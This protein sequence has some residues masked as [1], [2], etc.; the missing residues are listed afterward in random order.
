LTS[1]P[2]PEHD[3]GWTLG[4]LLPTIARAMPT[5][6]TSPGQG[7][8]RP[9]LTRATPELIRAT[10]QILLGVIPL[11]STVLFLGLLVGEHN[12]AVDFRGWYWP[13]GHRVL[14]GLSPYT[15]PPLRALNYPAFG[16]LLLAPFALI[17]HGAAD[18]V[19]TAIVLGSIPITL[20][21]LDVR[22]WRIYGIVLLWQPVIVGYETANV[23]LL[24]VLGLAAVW[25]FRDRAVVAGAVLAVILSIKMILL[26]VGLWLLLTNRFRAVA[27]AVAVG[28]VINLLSW[29]VLGFD[30]LPVYL[31]LIQA[32]PGLA[33]RWGYSL[34]GL[35]LHL[36][37]G[38]A[39]ADAVGIGAAVLVLA[40]VVVVRD[41]RRDETVLSG[42]IAACLLASPVVECHYL[43]LILIPLALARPRLEPIWALPLILIVIPPDHPL[44]WQHV[45]AIAVA[46]VVMT[47]AI[48]NR[49]GVPGAPAQRRSK[50]VLVPRVDTGRNS[51]EAAVSLAAGLPS[52]AITTRTPGASSAT[53]PPAKPP[54]QSR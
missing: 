27:A 5:P 35:A 25:R 50:S 42:C 33:E 16:A 3:H 28:I 12:V 4:R 21:L 34:I 13:A 47:Y 38:Q 41:E 26:P 36:G 7:R 9:R 51:P 30:Q 6:T 37:A 14:N 24:L 43:A 31:R 23:S 1:G 40:T 53:R 54:S 48:V 52:P 8:P 2:V 49:G 39:A 20:R 18:W 29:A 32:F 19:F 45:L 22:D 10:E 15:L 11:L 44:N 17:P 46:A